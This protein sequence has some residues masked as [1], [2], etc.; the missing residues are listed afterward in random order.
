M[1]T[2]L[3]WLI[4]IVIVVL[5]VGGIAA[6]M[7]W[8]HTNVVA[9]R[10]PFIVQTYGP[11]MMQGRGFDERG[12]G[13]GGMMGPGFHHGFGMMGGRGGFGF[14]P[15]GGLLMLPLMLLRGLFPLAIFGFAIYGIVA[16]FKRGKTIPAAPAPAPVAP[17]AV[18][19]SATCSS[20]GQSVQADWKHCPY[21]GNRL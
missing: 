5:V 12:F 20:C 21:C 17:A 15:F 19:S 9:G 10:A 13:P 11:G 7:Y 4:G 18:A 1:K 6:G 8:M 3:K 14:M 16:W 2:W